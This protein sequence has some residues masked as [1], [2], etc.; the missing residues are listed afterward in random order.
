MIPAAAVAVGVLVW[1]WFGGPRTALYGSSPSPRPAHPVEAPLAISAPTSARTSAPGRRL[2]L[3]AQGRAL[4]TLWTLT[5]SGSHGAVC[6][7]LALSAGS[8]D[9][10]TCW[11]GERGFV[12]ALRATAPGGEFWFGPAPLGAARAWVAL[13]DGRVVYGDVYHLPSDMRPSASAF[14]VAVPRP[15]GSGTVI[16]VGKLGRLVGEAHTSTSDVS[17]TRIATVDAY[18]NVIGYV[19]LGTDLVLLTPGRHASTTEVR[20]FARYRLRRIRPAIR[21]WWGSRPGPVAPDASFERWWTAY[22]VGH[23]TRRSPASR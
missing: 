17:A 7:S 5:S 4:G 22:P 19:P 2:P 11:H 3:V 12:E 1:W 6:L 15:A 21:E 14:M 18:G 9:S 20:Y 10:G 13:D 16:A 23:A 8:L